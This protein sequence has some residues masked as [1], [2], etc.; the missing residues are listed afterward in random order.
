MF[1]SLKKETRGIL[2][3]SFDAMIEKLD[4]NDIIGWILEEYPSRSI[5]DLALGY[6]L[7]FS[8]HYARNLVWRKKLEEEIDKNLEEK[9]LRKIEKDIEKAKRRSIWS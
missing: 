5:Q 2:E 1:L 9:G 4:I 7:G 8:S 3:E 6:V